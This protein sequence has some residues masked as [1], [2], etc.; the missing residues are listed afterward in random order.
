MREID[1]FVKI[2]LEFKYSIQYSANTGKGE[3]TLTSKLVLSK[4]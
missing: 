4:F 3:P 2:L 1:R